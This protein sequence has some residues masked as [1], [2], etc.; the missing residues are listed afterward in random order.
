MVLD[1]F[2]SSFP[3][4]SDLGGAGEQSLSDV[5]WLG[6]PIV[7]HLCDSSFCV[8]GSV[9]WWQRRT[10]ESRITKYLDFTELLS[11]C[12]P[13]TWFSSSAS[14]FHMESFYS[15]RKFSFWTKTCVF[16]III[17]IVSYSVPLSGI[18]GLSFSIYVGRLWV[19]TWL[20]L[21]WFLG[22]TEIGCIAKQSA[23]GEQRR[24]SWQILQKVRAVTLWSFKAQL[25]LVLTSLSLK[26]NEP[27]LLF[28]VL[29]SSLGSLHSSRRGQLSGGSIIRQERPPRAEPIA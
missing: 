27:S 1:D 4:I 14:R 16:I 21:V 13:L 24:N 6:A 2:C 9:I 23:S 10:E 22:P 17:I 28:C 7:C 18:F 15:G 20:P 3:P 12:N 19:F 25:P 11:C 5:A 26:D 8:M 29:T